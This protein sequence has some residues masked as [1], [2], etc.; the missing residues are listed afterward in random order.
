M[1]MSCE[2]CSLSISV[3]NELF[4]VCEGKCAKYFHADCV[5]VTES[6]LCT[7]SSNII[8][9]CNTCMVW[10]CRARENVNVDV[11]TNTPPA[12]SLG[13]EIDELKCTVSEMANTLAKVIQ[14]TESAALYRHSTPVSSPKALDGSSLDEVACGLIQQES[15]QITSQTCESDYF[16][17]Y[18]TNIDRCA[19]ENDISVMVSHSLNVPISCCTDVVK[20]VPR[21]KNT[22]TLDYVSFKVVLRV[23]L[24]P[25]ALTASTWPKG[26]KYR[27][28]ISRMNE[29]WKPTIKK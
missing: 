5:G 23:D 18:L 20:L 9:I 16:S 14:Q 25:L 8:W 12:R 2:K 28:F 10:L 19:T 4:T 11:A 1:A 22:N 17:L 29:T 21:N 26:M 6:A 13:D 3:A 27:E 7:L 15:M 24:K